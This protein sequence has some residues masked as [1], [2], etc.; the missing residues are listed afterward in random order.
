[1]AKTHYRNNIIEMDAAHSALYS[2]THS[3]SQDK[4]EIILAS[5]CSV[6]STMD[7]VRFMNQCFFKHSKTCL[8]VSN[9]VQTQD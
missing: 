3:C 9:A 4:T 7:L 2:F 8:I 5:T 6:L 1:M